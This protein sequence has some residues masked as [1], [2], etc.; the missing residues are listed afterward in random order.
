VDGWQR[1]FLDVEQI[2]RRLGLQIRTIVGP[3]PPRP[4][5]GGKMVGP[6]RDALARSSARQPSKARPGFYLAIG[7]RD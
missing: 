6:R 7:G 4:L 1:A 2:A 3:S 5:Q